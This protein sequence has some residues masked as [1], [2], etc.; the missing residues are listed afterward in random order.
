MGA[1]L[2]RLS[3]DLAAVNDN[4]N[5]VNRNLG[6]L[7]SAQPS[8]NSTASLLSQVGGRANF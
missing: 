1:G 6:T 5:N 3:S 4:L 7:I 2:D 8:G